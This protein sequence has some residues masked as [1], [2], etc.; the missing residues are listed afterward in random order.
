MSDDITLIS[1]KAFKD[2]RKKNF[3][4][5]REGFQK[6]ID[7]LSVTGSEND[8]AEMKNN[9]S[10]TLIELREAQLAYDTV[11]GTDEIFEKSNDK[12]SQAM[13]LANIGTALQVLGRKEEALIT[14]EKSSELF[15]ETNEKLM[16][17]TILKKISDIQLSAGKPMEAIVALQ[18]SYEMKD[19]KSFIDKI[20]GSAVGQIFRRIIK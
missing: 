3:V 17:A 4:A 1:A 8:L 2:Y 12:K 6:C 9:L 15:K 20:L 5:A 13:A 19:N 14:F 18:A 16:R 11:F 10:V 7:L